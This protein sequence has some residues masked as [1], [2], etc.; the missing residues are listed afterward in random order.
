[1][2]EV[3][4]S[5]SRKDEEF[6]RW[7]ADNLGNYG[8]DVWLDVRN[9]SPGVKWSTAIQQALTACRAMIIIIS[10]DSMASK[11][12]EDEWQYYLDQQ[13]ILIP[14]LYRPADVHFQLSRVQYIDFF[15]QDHQV[16]FNQLAGQLQRLG[17]RVGY[18]SGTDP[19][20]YIPHQQPLP[21][22]R[23]QARARQGERRWLWLGGVMSLLVVIAVVIGV[24]LILQRDDDDPPPGP[25][26]TLVPG[27]DPRLELVEGSNTLLRRDE[28]DIQ[29]YN[30]MTL[31]DEDYLN[32]RSS[33]VRGVFQQGAFAVTQRETLVELSTITDPARPLRLDLTDGEVYLERGNW[34]DTAVICTPEPICTQ[35]TA[36]SVRMRYDEDTLE[37]VASCFTGE[38]AVVAEDTGQVRDIPEG[39]QFVFNAGDDLDDAELEDIPDED[40]EDYDY[41]C[42]GDCDLGGGPPSDDDDDDAGEGREPAEPFENQIAYV[43]IPAP[44]GE[45]EVVVQLMDVL[46]MDTEGNLVR[47]L[48]EI[49]PGY[50]LAMDWSPDGSQ[51]VVPWLDLSET[52]QRAEESGVFEYSGRLYVIN[53]D[54]SDRRELAASDTGIMFAAWS[55][56]GEPIV[57]SEIVAYGEES[58]LAA[59]MTIHPDGSG[60]R[61]LT[62]PAEEI[63]RPTWSPDGSALA[64]ASFSG[65]SISI[66][67]RDGD[68]ERVVFDAPESSIAG[69]D[70]S[71]DGRWLAFDVDLGYDG[72]SDIYLISPEGGEPRQLT[73]NEGPDMMPAWS[74]D[75]SQ[76]AFAS[77]RDGEDLEIYVM[78]ADGS[79]PRQLTFNED[80]DLSPVWKPNPGVEVVSFSPETPE[81]RDVCFFYMLSADPEDADRRTEWANSRLDEMSP[82]DEAVWNGSPTIA[83]IPDQELMVG[84]AT[85]FQF[86]VFDEEGDEFEVFVNS[87]NPDIVEAYLVDYGAIELVAHAP[88]QIQVEVV[89]VDE[90]GLESGYRFVVHVFQGEDG[91]PTRNRPPVL[92]NVS[93][94]NTF[95][96]VGDI[97]DGY[98]EAEDPDGDEF[99]IFVESSDPNVAEV[100]RPDFGSFRIFANAPGTTIITVIAEDEWGAIVESRF[101]MIVYPDRE[102]GTAEAFSTESV[103]D[104]VLLPTYATYMFVPTPTLPYAATAV[105]IA[106]DSATPDQ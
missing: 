5:Y 6:A 83:E 63:L 36:S 58:T 34:G 26:R 11:N 53:A 67:N 106:T 24:V 75:G 103:G 89:A 70:W 49:P 43:S 29:V 44:E 38:C 42:G 71:P 85:V 30:N 74:P 86:E 60:R 23:Q 1:M 15:N 8:V 64:V 62:E 95:V 79:D 101:E 40:Y 78:N 52:M 92:F 55:P 82:E 39:K 91:A 21:V 80:E 35:A 96:Y 33:R 87:C 32:T 88:G 7:L 13:K 59:L 14:V 45:D 46:I 105:Y 37:I 102:V 100:S 2:A 41:L 65:S 20:T 22:R 97:V 4:I 25:I 48:E 27:A 68:L 61:E 9:I 66:L 94:E 12:V 81:E 17:M 10:P 90:T 18:I 3:F 51:L 104:P 93:V 77:S 57:F 16:A 73:F 56:D 76:I 50:I 28:D 47:R 54:G 31:Q 69:I 72:N 99:S 19:N 84:E 98:V